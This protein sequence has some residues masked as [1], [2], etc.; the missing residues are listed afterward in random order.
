MIG[1]VRALVG[2]IKI[3]IGVNRGHGRGQ[4]GPEM[5]LER[6]IRTKR[7]L[8]KVDKGLYSGQ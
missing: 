7:I 4:K 8:I 3:L 1:S 6:S 5:V 2:S